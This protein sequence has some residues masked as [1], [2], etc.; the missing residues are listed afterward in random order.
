MFLHVSVRLE[1]VQ[2]LSVETESEGSV[3]VRWRGVTGARAYRLVWGPFTGQNKA[4]IKQH[5]A[6][7][8]GSTHVFFNKFAYA[9]LYFLSFVSVHKGRNVETVEVDGDSNF[10]TLSRLQPDTEYIVTIITLYEGNTEGPAATARFKIG[11]CGFSSSSQC[12]NSL[13]EFL[14]IGK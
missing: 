10:Y 13:S 6:C 12:Q 8:Q 11:R 4:N 14:F 5:L 1:A 9:S 3:R 7:L 2:Q